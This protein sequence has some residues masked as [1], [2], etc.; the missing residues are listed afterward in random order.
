MTAT[1]P[2]GERQNIDIGAIEKELTALWK[3]PTS[4]GADDT[5]ITRACVMTLIAPVSGR[6]ASNEATQLVAQLTDRFPNRAIV[7]EATS[8]GDDLLDAWVQ[9]HCQMPGAGHSQ[10]CCEQITIEAH[11]PAVS[12]VPGAVL[13]LLVP[14][15]PVIV[16]WSHGAPFDAPLFARLSDYADRVIVDST[17]FDAPEAQ[18]DAILAMLG[19]RRSASDLAWGRLTPWRELVAQFFDSPAMIPHLH[20]LDRVSVSYRQR[21]G[22]T[23]DRVQPL[24]FIGW[25]A[26]KLGWA[27]PPQPIADTDSLSFTLERPDGGVV[28]IELHGSATHEH[29]DAQIELVELGCAHAQYRIS[30]DEASGN[31]QATANVAGMPP[32]NRVVRMER[33]DT[34][35]LLAEELRVF[36][37]DRGY[38]GALQV[39]ARL[40][41]EK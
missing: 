40:V 6:R 27:A 14:D 20:E 9:A 7:I 22:G 15:V 16:W 30:R 39:A 21:P 1:V 37:R 12:R 2:L 11:G 26:A 31:A 33:Q 23:R 3:Q 17:T 8:D 36:G 25:L 29:S 41:R 4:E 18:L 19:A 5:H 32:I 24:L 35:A 13:P 28:T 38:E 10:I 34:A